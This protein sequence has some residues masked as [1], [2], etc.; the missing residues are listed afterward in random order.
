MFCDII[1]VQSNKSL[2][3]ATL[4]LRSLRYTF[5]KREN[6]LT[7]QDYTNREREMMDSKSI[8]MCCPFV[9]LFLLD[10]PSMY[11]LETIDD[12][13]RGLQEEAWRQ[14]KTKI[15]CRNIKSNE[16]T[17]KTCRCIFRY[18]GRKD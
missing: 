6:Q 13:S 16:T 12:F 18:V 15:R 3:L 8:E 10:S 9:S 4:S 14:S 1:F 2:L 7:L 11:R 5:G 17:R